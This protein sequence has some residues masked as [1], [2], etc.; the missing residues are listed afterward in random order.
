MT[1]IGI[2]DEAP[3]EEMDPFFTIDADHQTARELKAG[4]WALV[5]FYEWAGLAE[6]G[7]NG[8]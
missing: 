5:D 4:L 8:G 2:S 7:R 6:E 3:V 1:A